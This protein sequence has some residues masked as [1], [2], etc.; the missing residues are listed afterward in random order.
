MAN[1]IINTSVFY[2]DKHYKEKYLS[3][4]PVIYKIPVENITEI[5]INVPHIN[6]IVVAS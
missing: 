4:M 3:H 6:H 5:T 2:M 1:I